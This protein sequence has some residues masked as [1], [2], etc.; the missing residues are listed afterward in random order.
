MSTDR[1]AAVMPTGVNL[2]VWPMVADQ[3]DLPA[4]SCCPCHKRPLRH[5]ETTT[6]SDRA[7]PSS[8]CGREFSTQCPRAQ[9]TSVPAS[10]PANTNASN[11]YTSR[12]CSST[13]CQTRTGVQAVSL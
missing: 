1:E 4:T 9:H 5:A 3:A 13:L 12:N 11:T 2:A 10:T 7:K 6:A 8:L